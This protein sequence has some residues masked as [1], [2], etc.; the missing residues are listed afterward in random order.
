MAF[1]KDFGGVVPPVCTPFTSEGDI[2]VPS[3]ERLLRY[4]LDNGATGI[5]A[6]GSTSETAAL[7]DAERKQVLE[8]TVGTVAGQ[9][10][11]LAGV[12]DMSTARVIYHGQVAREAGVD[13]LVSCGPYYIR[14]SQ[15]EIITHFRLLKDAV[16]LPVMAYDVPA[17]VQIVLQKETV[18]ALGEE[19][20]VIGLKDSS[21]NE[22]NFRAVTALT[23]HLDGFSIFTGSELTAD[24]AMFTGASGIVPG[25]GNVDPAGYRRLYDHAVSGD[26][27]AARVEQARLTALFDVIWQAT[28]GRVGFTA[29]ALGGFKTALRELGVIDTNMMATPMTPLNDE[30]A[31][32]IRSVLERAGML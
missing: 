16:G 11:V 32:R 10:P 20:T 28:P 25:L 14:P 8:V 6:L 17:N 21:G 9:V 31:A 12:I 2:D 5:F 13:A 3:L 1:Q 22:N 23:S 4:Q 19:G 30:E 24:Y 29:G 18:L 15:D 7:S 27:D 26:W